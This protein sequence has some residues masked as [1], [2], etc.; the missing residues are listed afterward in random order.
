MNL[1]DIIR[2][3]PLVGY[4]CNCDTAQ[5]VTIP[6]VKNLNNMDFKA[7]SIEIALGDSSLVY[8]A[9]VVKVSTSLFGIRYYMRHWF[10][11]CAFAFIACMSTTMFFSMLTFYF[12]IKGSIKAVL[13]RFYPEAKYYTAVSPTTPKIRKNFSREILIDNTDPFTSGEDTSDNDSTSGKKTTA[14]TANDEDQREKSMT[15]RIIVF[16]FKALVW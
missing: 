15:E 6:I 11:T 9:A 4:L 8:Q 1:K 7:S 10:L 2:H 14:S 16:I 3:L 5:L 12:I 13:L